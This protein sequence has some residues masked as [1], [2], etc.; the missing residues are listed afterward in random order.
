[1]NLMMET[2]K[3][4]RGAA[5]NFVIEE[6]NGRW[7]VR[8]QPT[9]AT[10]SLSDPTSH[11]ELRNAIRKINNLIKF[12]GGSKPMGYRSDVLIAI[13]FSSVE[14]RDAVWAVYCIAP[15]VQEQNLSEVWNRHDGAPYPV[16]W[17]YEDDT[18]WYDTYDDAQALEYMMGLV[19]EFAQERNLPY[20]YV[21]Q[22]IGADF[23]DIEIVERQDGDTGDDMRHMLWERC[24]IE[25]RITHNFN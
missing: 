11:T 8:H 9:G 10:Y 13:A 15:R 25:R 18:E 4:T 23:T 3:D 5:P 16:L 24:G 6:A 19:S 1:M 12:T 2:I 17:F 20:A 21:F 22:R 7:V 14:H